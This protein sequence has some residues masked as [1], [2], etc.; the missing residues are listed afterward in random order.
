MLDNIRGRT[1]CKG[2]TRGDVEHQNMKGIISLEI[3]ALLRQV[4]TDDATAVHLII[5]Q[6]PIIR[7]GEGL[8]RS[9]KPPVDARV[10]DDFA[11]TELSTQQHA[12]LEH[13]G[14]ADST[15]RLDGRRFLC[16]IF[17]E[18]GQF[19]ATI[20]ILPSDLPSLVDLIAVEEELSRMVKLLQ[21]R[22]GMIL[23][24]GLAGSGRSSLAAAMIDAINASQVKRIATIEDPPRYDIVSRQAVVTQHMVGHDVESFHA[25]LETVRGLDADVVFISAIP[26][27]QT[28]ESAAALAQRGM[29]VI[30]LTR[31]ATV[32]A[33]I[34]G[35]FDA[36]TNQHDR[37]KELLSQNLQAIVSTTLLPRIDLRERVAAHEIMIA[38]LKIRS[39]LAEGRGEVGPLMK[40]GRQIGMQQLD[41]SLLMLYKA[42]MISFDEAEPRMADKMLLGRRPH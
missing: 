27:F 9:D 42:G 5:G 34:K 20:R 21:F 41:D 31:F 4:L 15:F 16:R 19:A 1:A 40:E 13:T 11:T 25:G 14:Y 3:E 18:L 28:F 33:C 17:R 29:L 2:N 32:G 36:F 10:I 23:I 7:S 8:V 39:A 6:P 26:D 24:T 37:A 22:R 35:L 38:S 30:A 12:T